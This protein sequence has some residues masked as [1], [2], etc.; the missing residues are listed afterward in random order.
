MTEP[1]S[2]AVV[3][4][5]MVVSSLLNASRS[6][7]TAAAYRS[8]I[9]GRPI[10]VSFVTVT[11]LRYGAIKAEWGELRR[12]SL[13]RDLAR[14]VIVQPTTRRCRSAP[15]CG[16]AANGRAWRWRRR[17]TRL[18]DGSQRPRSCWASTWSPRTRC[19]VTWPG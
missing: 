11:E 5:T 16:P 9:G 13:E 10:V 2:P 18:T 7:Q 15:T 4:D 12:R 8:L 14:L 6:P 17:F 19:S 1:V 3:V